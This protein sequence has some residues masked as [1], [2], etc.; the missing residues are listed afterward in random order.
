MILTQLG[1]YKINAWLGGGQFGDVYLAW[2]TILEREFAIKVARM[3][4]QDI[5]MLK[6]EAKLLASLNHPNI[7]RFFNIDIIEGKLVLVMEYIKGKSLRDMLTKGKLPCDKAIN[8]MV[9]MLDAI[10]YAH[11]RGVIHRDLKP[12]NILITSDDTV[13]ITD[14]GL[15]KFLREGSLSASIAGTPIY[16]AP[17]AWRGKFYQQSD[18]YSAGVIFYEMLTGKPAF[19]GDSLDDIREKIFNSYPPKVTVFNPKVPAHIDKVIRKAI[20]KDPEARFSTADEFKSAIL[21]PGRKSGVAVEVVKSPTEVFEEEIT[22]TPQQEEIINSDAPQILVL[23]GPGTGKTVTLIYRVA[24]LLREGEPPGSFLIVG[25]TRRAVDDMRTRLE[26]IIGK[27]LRNLVI[28]T[29]HTLAYRILKHDGKRLGFKEDFSI[30]NAWHVLRSIAKGEELSRIEAMLERIELYKANLISPERAKQLARSEWDHECAEI[31]DKYQ[32][33][34]KDKQMMDLSDLIYYSV[35]VLREPDIGTHYREIFKWVFADELQDLTPAQYEL[36]KLLAGGNIFFTGD[37]N[38][39]IYSWRGGMHRFRE[40]VERDFPQVKVYLLT[41]NFRIPKKI[42]NAAQTLVSKIEGETHPSISLRETEGKIELQSYE[43]ESEEAWQVGAQIEELVKKHGFKFS[44][45]AII[46]RINAISSVFENTLSS[47]NIPYMLVEGETFYARREIKR[48]IK[49]LERLTT[50]NYQGMVDFIMWVLMLPKTYKKC[51]GIKNK[52][53][54]LK[55]ELPN[56]LDKERLTSYLER[57]NTILREPSQFGVSEILEI[58]LID[59]GFVPK[60]KVAQEISD[61]NRAYNLEELINAARSFGRGEIR[62]FLNHIALLE[63]LQVAQWGKDTVKLL[64][65]HQAKGLEFKV[66]FLVSLT[67]DIFPLMR[68]TLDPDELD[69]ERRLFYVALTRATEHVYLSYPRLRYTRKM[70]PS[71]FLFELA[72]L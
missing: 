47:F 19:L 22:L 67:D 5:V 28:D 63:E 42:L 64:T 59:S 34:L 6:D 38:Q 27:E 66:V 53:I 56:T 16:M 52:Q 10:H 18:I 71:R 51:F 32:R 3:R 7:V 37:E 35:Q 24:K 14:F 15:G 11:T 17:E 43:N 36:I 12:E 40:R 33:A 30:I 20:D 2:D 31:Y 21:S 39:S 41:N 23:G 61:I 60:L 57:F 68:A 65:A 55:G 50:G 58:A 44:D 46:Y 4:E 8:Y 29:V 45:I 13:K 9:Q 54:V 26:H 48:C 70:K 72:G 25:F 49:F 69:E 1:K 62:E